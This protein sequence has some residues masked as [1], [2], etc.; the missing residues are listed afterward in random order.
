MRFTVNGPVESQVAYLIRDADGDISG[1]EEV[2]IELRDS[3]KML[4]TVKY[5]GQA[6][7]TDG[8]M[9]YESLPSN[10]TEEFNDRALMSLGVAHGVAHRKANEV[11]AT[12][13]GR[14]E[15]KF[16]EELRKER[17]NNE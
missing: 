11:L 8:T 9:E 6:V 15:A 12:L 3:T 10:R 16:G 2:T 1:G 17:D 4:Y 5:A 14:M 7:F 13:S